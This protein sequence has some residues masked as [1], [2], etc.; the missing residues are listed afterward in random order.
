MRRT[1]TDIPSSWC[2]GFEGVPGEEPRYADN[3]LVDYVLLFGHNVAYVWGLGSN[4]QW[5][6]N[7]CNSH[8]R[9]G[10]VKVAQHVFIW[11]TRSC[12]YSSF[13]KS[14]GDQNRAKLV[15][16]RKVLRARSV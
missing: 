5:T 13:W 9:L 4:V 1:Y 14:H 2:F 15:W 10:E 6:L 16:G 8:K 7:Y 11:D 3:G 12:K